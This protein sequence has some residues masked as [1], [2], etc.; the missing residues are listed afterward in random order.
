MTSWKVPLFDLD[1]DA[2]EADA[3]RD[4]LDSRW[5]TMG[6]RTADFEARF[7]EHLGGGVRCT[8]VSSCTAALHMALHLSGVGPGDEV[9]VSGLTFVAAVNAVVMCGATPV[10]ADA[11]S[12]DDWNVSPADLSARITGR[13]RALIIV[14]YA[15][16]PC[17][18]DAITA[19]ARAAGVVLIEDVAHAVGAEYRGRKCGTFGDIACFSFFSNKNLSTGE[20]GMFVTPHE[21][22]D[23]RARLFRSHGMTSLTVDRHNRRS[24]SYDVLHPG[25]N[26]RMDELRSAIGIVQLQKLPAN[27]RR[28][29]ELVRTYHAALAGIPGLGIPWRELP[30]DVLPAF[31]ICT[32]LLPPGADRLRLM[33]HLREQGIQTSIHYPSLRGFACY[34]SVFPDPLPVADLICA[35]ALTLPLHPGLKAD[36]IE[37]VCENLA[38]GLV[39]GV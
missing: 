4:V 11:V 12:P 2:R 28:R 14:H 16:Y 38:A 24:L 13:T 39:N 34:R 35:R 15:G 3:V 26:Y 17:D 9:V 18:M 30:R 29:A 22:L 6:P 19:L 10:L 7:A 25:L 27:N 5:L 32:V 36:D 31:H 23:A 20:G 1:F 21:D 37:C 8:A 33:E